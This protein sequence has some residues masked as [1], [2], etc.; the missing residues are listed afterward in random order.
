MNPQLIVSKMHWD[1]RSMKVEIEKQTVTS[2]PELP[3]P[4]P[5]TPT[6]AKVDKKRVKLSRR[7]LMT[8]LSTTDSVDLEYLKN[9]MK[10][11]GG[12]N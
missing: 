10:S 1:L 3:A 12:K 5:P 11:V 2:G 4:L 6:Q 7:S 9:R 8:L